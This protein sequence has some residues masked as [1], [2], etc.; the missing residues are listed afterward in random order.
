[1]DKKDAKKF[2][3]LYHKEN[4]YALRTFEEVEE[5][6][7]QRRLNYLEMRGEQKK[8]NFSSYYNSIYALKALDKGYAEKLVDDIGLCGISYST[9]SWILANGMYNAYKTCNMSV[10]KNALHT[11]NRLSF[12]NRLMLCGGFNHSGNFE[13]VIYA[14]ADCDI[15]LV[16]KYLPKQ[17]GL[18]DNN[19]Y[20]FFRPCCNLIMGMVYQNSSWIKEAQ[21]QVERFK[22]RK[23]SPKN[24]ILVACYLLA[25]SEQ[26]T[27]EASQL[28]QEIV[29]NYRKMTWIFNF[30]SEFRKFFGIYVHGLYNIGY[31]VLSAERFSQI[32][33]PEHSVF[34]KEL[35]SYT[36]EHGFATGKNIFRLE[37]ELSGLKRLFDNGWN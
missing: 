5:E 32:Q 8:I 34:W 21:Q 11:K 37:G 3:E 4:A 27:S 20:P 31:F 13:R 14:F 6:L 7:R 19:T 1:M 16:E 23:S 25:L 30:T 35:D 18:A 10:L 33:V 22:Q 2:E 17:L 9:Y 29:A 12:G 24:D 36:K 28:L 15:D 26:N